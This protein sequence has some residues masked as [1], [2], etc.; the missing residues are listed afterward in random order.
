MIRFAVACYRRLAP[1]P[2]YVYALV[3]TLI[4]LGVT[5]ALL[6]LQGWAWHHYHLAEEALGRYRL[7]EAQAHLNQALRVWSADYRTH[8][9]AGQTA[10]RLGQFDEAEKHLDYCQKL[11]GL[12][13]EV[14]LERA[15]LRAQRGGMDEMTAYLK[16][17]VEQGDPATPLI[18]EAMAQGYM[19]AYRH[20]DAAAVLAEWLG[21]SPDDVEANYLEGYV[22]EQIG[23]AS[24]AVKHYQHVVELDPEHE[25]ARLHL[26][27]LLIDQ[28][29]PADALPHAEY[30]RRKQPA[31]PE[32]LVLLARCHIALGHQEEAREILDGVLASSPHFR[33]ALCARGELALQLDQPAVAEQ[34]L[35]EALHEDPADYQSQFHLYLSLQQQGK[36]KEAQAVQKRLALMETDIRRLR[37]I[38]RDEIGKSPRDPVLLTEIGCI[39]LRAGSTREGVQW[40]QTALEYD[41]RYEP[42]HRA[43]AEHYERLGNTE[44]ATRHRRFLG[45]ERAPAPTAA[46]ITKAK[47][48]G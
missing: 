2:R 34:A 20:T 5:L 30:L 7:A 24:M 4:A 12:V 33:P 27:T 26:C 42:A 44:Q 32:V 41:P 16:P 1:R 11:R 18:L 23:P 35:A 39:L 17:L 47:P 3:L 38:V 15:L 45:E 9:L 48:G 6:G 14:R 29:H 25:E 10:R 13:T 28:A 19:H 21:R 46:G 43:L 36:D 31:N 22:R 8:L 37:S 40:L